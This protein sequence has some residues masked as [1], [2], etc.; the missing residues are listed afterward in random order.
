M[1]GIA[2][3]PIPDR[4]PIA[5]PLVVAATIARWV[6]GRAWAEVVTDGFGAGS[7]PVAGSEPAG[8]HARVGAS[9]GNGR[10]T[11][12]GIVVGVIALIVAA[13]ASRGS[14]WSEYGIVRGNSTL[15]VV[16]L[17]QV[18]VTAMAAELALRGW[19]VE[20]VL[21][22]AQPSESEER[23]S[24]SPR[25]SSSDRMPG[26]TLLA[27]LIGAIAEAVITPGDVSAR[28]AAGLFGAG[29]GWLYI[30]GGRNVMTPIAARVAFQTGA[31]LIEALRLT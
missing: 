30:V 18:A 20:R 21:E 16:I 28:L 11:L 27:V 12:V 29:F 7:D 5:L 26:V 14:E 23:V 8:G 15:L 9:I 10:R 6:R 13:I 19:I 3:A 1:I 4:I 24:D 25:A 22:L 2:V 17:I 31:V